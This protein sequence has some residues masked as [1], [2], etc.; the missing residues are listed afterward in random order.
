MDWAALDCD[1]SVEADALVKI[2]PVCGI[3]REQ[4]VPIALLI[5]GESYSA[6]VVT[7]ATRWD[8]GT[9][10]PGLPRRGETCPLEHGMS[11]RHTMI[12]IEGPVPG[13]DIA[14]W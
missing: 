1:L 6:D 8:S 2:I 10:W 11:N 3:T 9:V 14:G 12:I 7:H 4:S 13:Y 5:N